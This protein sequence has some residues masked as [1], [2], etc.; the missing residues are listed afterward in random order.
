MTV[1]QLENQ[2][3]QNRDAETDH[4]DDQNNE[5]HHHERIKIEAQNRNA[6]M[7]K[8]SEELII[9]QQNEERWKKERLERETND[10]EKTRQVE[11]MR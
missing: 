11:T 5:R 3:A 7:I 4:K 10:H 2:E 1:E 9:R 8:E 6:R